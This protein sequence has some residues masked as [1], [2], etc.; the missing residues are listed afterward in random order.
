M[1]GISAF[2]GALIGVCVVSNLH[3]E[4]P[5]V[6]DHVGADAAVAQQPQ[7]QFRN[8][9]PQTA[10]PQTAETETAET[11]SDSTLSPEERINVAVY[12]KVN[13]SVVNI[14]TIATRSDFMF[15]LE[16]EEG[17]GSGWVYDDQGHI[18]TNHHVIA[19]SDVIEV[20]MYDG[21]SFT[22]GVV[23]TDPQNDVAVLKIGAEPSSLNPVVLGDS[24]KLRVGQKIL[25]IGNPFGLERTM[26]VG[27]VSS[28]DRTLRSKNGRL[29]KQ[30]IQLDAALNQGNSGGPLLSSNGLLVGMN[31]AIA[32]LTGENTGVGF[33]IPVNTIR[34]VVPQ[35]IQFGRVQRASLGVDLFWKTRNGLRIAQVVP[36][37]AADVAGLKGIAIERSVRQIGGQM[38]RVER[39]NREVADR[40]VAI[41][42]QQI[43]DTDD[44]QSVLE[45]YKPGQQVTVTI[46]RNGQIINVPVVL[47]QEF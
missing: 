24:S 13:R 28:L 31:T 32:S 36:G 19:D 15:R 12:E 9:V 41:D 47:G 46:D 17:S 21:T 18:V 34:R 40:I 10:V 6:G 37:G 4:A 29:M 26:T 23:G 3:F 25:A 2:V 5:L 44:V 39:Y 14:S 11:E 30:I 7:F 1:C 20:T 16:P 22:A 38:V 8:A 45:K 27:I 33:A 35:L 43:V 42:D